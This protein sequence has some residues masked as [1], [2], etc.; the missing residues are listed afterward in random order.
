[1]L[2]VDEAQLIK[3]FVINNSAVTYHCLHRVFKKSR[4]E[5]NGKVWSYTMVSKCRKLPAEDAVSL[6]GE[7]ASIR[8]QLKISVPRL[9]RI[10][11]FD[12][13]DPLKNE[14]GVN[15]RIVEPGEPINS[16]ADL[17]LIPGSKSTIGDL[18][19]WLSRDGI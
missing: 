3:G 1:M 14:S 10:A 19:F 18:S 16:D 4:N 6:K 5:H 17:I 15:L 8:Q 12:D 9:S 2:P 13:L 7:P 11:N